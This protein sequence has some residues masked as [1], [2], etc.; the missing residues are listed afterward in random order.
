MV[1]VKLLYKNVRKRGLDRPRLLEQVFRDI[2][3]VAVWRAF[4]RFQNRRRRLAHKCRVTIDFVVTE[5]AADLREYVRTRRG[6][7]ESELRPTNGIVV[8]RRNGGELLTVKAKMLEAR[9]CRSA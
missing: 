1:Y 9:A 2:G 6:A 7:V 3:E 8:T 4:E 5:R